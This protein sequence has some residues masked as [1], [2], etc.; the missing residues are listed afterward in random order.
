MRSCSRHPAQQGVQYMHEAG[1]CRYDAH[2]DEGEPNADG[3]LADG[4]AKRIKHTVKVFQR[5]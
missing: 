2:G 1:A 3:K 4:S 5:K